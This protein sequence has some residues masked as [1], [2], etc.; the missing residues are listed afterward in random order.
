LEFLGADALIN[1]YVS[2]HNETTRF[3]FTKVV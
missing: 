1:E 3:D 2:T